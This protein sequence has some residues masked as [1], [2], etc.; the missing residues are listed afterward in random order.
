MSHPS[1][2]PRARLSAAFSAVMLALSAC[3]GLRESLSNAPEGVP[4]VLS[5]LNAVGS[6]VTF[7]EPVSAPTLLVKSLTVGGER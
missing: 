5:G 2:R 6:R 1:R 4:S 7:S 3:A